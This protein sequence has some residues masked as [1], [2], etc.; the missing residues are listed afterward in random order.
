MVAYCQL[1]KLP[2]PDPFGGQLHPA[3]PV[4]PTVPPVAPLSLHPSMQSN[5]I[6]VL[7]RPG[8]APVPHAKPPAVTTAEIRSMLEGNYTEKD[9]P[10][11]AQYCASAYAKTPQ[12]QS[13]YVRYYTKLYR[14]KLIKVR[15]LKNK[16]IVKKILNMV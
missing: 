4:V 10:T 3:I 11:L 1:D 7:Q 16:D 5:N 2:L 8:E 13:A 14:D 9:I 12:E 15:K 6:P